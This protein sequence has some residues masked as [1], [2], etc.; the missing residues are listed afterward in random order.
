MQVYAKL[1]QE[2]EETDAEKLRNYQTQTIS[3]PAI[4]LP[5]APETNQVSASA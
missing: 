4:A 5:E 3:L 2:H 1:T